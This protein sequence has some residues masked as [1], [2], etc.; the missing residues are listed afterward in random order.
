MGLCCIAPVVAA[1]VFGTNSGGPGVKMTLG[2]RG[3][4]W[5]YNGAIDAA[6]SFGNE[7][8][9]CDIDNVVFDPVN[10][11][12]TGPCYMKD[13]ASTSAVYE[14]AKAVVDNVAKEIRGE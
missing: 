7:M 12:T 2:S 5:P 6:S 3:D 4:D 1:K 13:T 10:K 8:V 11:I 9:D 14:N